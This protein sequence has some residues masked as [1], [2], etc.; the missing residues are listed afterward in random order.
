MTR[1]FLGVDV[2]ATKTHALIAEENGQ[3]CGFGEAGP[4]NHEGV[5]Y[6]GLAAALRTATE[7][8][9]ARAGLSI[10]QIAGAGFGVAGYDWPSERE[11]T[12][13]AIRTLGLNVPFEAVND[14]I[15]GLLAGAPE[16]WG[17]AVVAGTGCNCWG[18]DR[19]HRRIGRVTG[20]GWPMAEAAGAGELVAEAIRC[21]ARD[22][23]LRGP[24]TRLTQAFVELVGAW[25]AEDLLEGI[26]QERC[27]ISADA[28]PLVFRAAAQG[29]PVAQQLIEWAGRELGSL[30]I[31]VI[32]QL[33]MQ[34]LEFDVVLVGSLYDGGPLLTDTMRQTVHAV[35]PGAR[36]VRLTAPP[37]VGGVLL[38]MEQAGLN[39]RAVRERLIETTQALSNPSTIQRSVLTHSHIPS[40]TISTVPD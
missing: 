27:F 7:Q 5:G 37:V 26:T 2:G 1:Y 17:I 6:D 20:M 11:P 9:L 36:F 19:Y 13:R 23:S 30:T 18:W 40:A 4:G 8:A 32:R 12:L 31:G 39:G 28:A 24:S 14:T 38:G 29:D 21:V 35:A 10:A 3:V 34:S 15:I 25:D 33:G 16:G 22:W